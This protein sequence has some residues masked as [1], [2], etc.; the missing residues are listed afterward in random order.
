MKKWALAAFF[1]LLLVI[2]SYA[3]YEGFFAEE[4]VNNEEHGQ[5]HQD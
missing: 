3:I 5:N 2:G 1:Y 4:V